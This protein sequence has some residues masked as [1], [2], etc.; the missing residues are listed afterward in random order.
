MKSMQEVKHNEANEI[1]PHKYTNKYVVINKGE[2]TVKWSHNIIIIITFILL[3]GYLYVHTY[4][5]IVLG[6]AYIKSPDKF[7]KFDLK[8]KR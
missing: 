1:A 6:Q 8:K 7:R 3:I 4:W 5:I 2:A